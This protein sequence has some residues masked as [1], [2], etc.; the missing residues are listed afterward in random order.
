MDWIT[1]PDKNH[2]YL[3]SKL[4]DHTKLLKRKKTEARPGQIQNP[5]KLCD[6]NMK[7]RDK[8]DVIKFYFYQYLSRG[9]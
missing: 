1:F 4:S 8:D 5:E 2:L 6:V 3:Y 9:W 7:L